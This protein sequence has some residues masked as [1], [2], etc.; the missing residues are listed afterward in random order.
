MAFGQQKELGKASDKTL[1]PMTKISIIWAISF[2]L[3][4][5]TV[6]EAHVAA[7]EP[8][9]KILGIAEPAVLPDSGF[10]FFKEIG[11]G[12]R[13]F[14]TFD[15]VKKAELELEIADEKLAELEK[16]VTKSE[17]PED[18]I[19]DAFDNY[20]EAHE[21]LAERLGSLKGKN[22]NVDTLLEK[23]A[24]RVVRHEELFNDLEDELKEGE[25]KKV[26]KEIAN[27]AKK[28]L[29]LDEKKFKEKLKAK[30][31]KEKEDDDEELEAIEDL[32]EAGG[33]L[34]ELEEDLGET[35][36]EARRSA[37]KEELEESEEEIDA[38]ED[39][40]KDAKLTGENAE[41]AKRLLAEANKHWGVAKR[42]FEKENYEQARVHLRY[43]A[44][45]LRDLGNF[46]VASKKSMDIDK[47]SK[48][49]K[50]CG[51]KP[52]APGN[53]VC[54]DKRWQLVEEKPREPVI[55]TQQYDPVCGADGK[56]YSNSCFAEAAGVKIRPK[57]ECAWAS[58]EPSITVL[59]PNGGENL[60][61]GQPYDI[62]WTSS[63]LGKGNAVA[64]NLLNFDTGRSQGIALVYEG[65]DENSISWLAT[66]SSPSASGYKIVIESNCSARG[67][68]CLT[69]DSSDAPFNIIFPEPTVTAAPSPQ[70]QEFKLEADDFGF[71]PSSSITASKGAKVKII[72]AVRPTG[73][74]YGGLDFRSSKFSSKNARPGESTDV[75]F[76]A[77]ESFTVTSYWPLSGVKKA[78][79]KVEVK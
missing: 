78:E 27:A 73:V 77:D 75:E 72:F 18:A 30:I 7:R 70:T 35:F 63:N 65:I 3:I 42:E 71:Y 53:W 43:V 29:E 26:E 10:Y 60:I 14:F 50:E 5:A 66:S 1:R 46:L 44:G 4:L 56:K 47:K 48:D 38:Y 34:K 52:G 61:R 32:I 23:L 11:R 58:A 21:R 64:I 20:L 59:Y 22:K 24:D 69:T 25:V 68:F 28:A 33:E 57:S 12:F 45:F 16:V 36:E 62:R 15:T 6:T 40:V 19:K 8:A 2:V 55:C 49:F 79:M 37:A 41:E 51:P 74:Y 17:A 67:T 13:R 76:V 9:F 39:R 31:E 54:K